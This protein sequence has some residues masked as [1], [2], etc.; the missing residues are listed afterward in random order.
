MRNTNNCSDT[1]HLAAIATGIALSELRELRL[2]AT[3]T[4]PDIAREKYGAESAVEYAYAETSIQ[5]SSAGE[6]AG[7]NP[8]TCEEAITL[9]AKEPWKAA[10]DK[11]VASLKTNS[12]ETLL[13]ATSLTTGHHIIGSK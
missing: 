4:L 1:A 2:Y 3:A 12:I 9:S 5:N 8:N 7:K 6:K 10:S 13:P 11:G